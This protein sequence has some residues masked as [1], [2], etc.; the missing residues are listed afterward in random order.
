VSYGFTGIAVALM[1]N[2]NPVGIFLSGILFG[3]LQNG[4]LKMQTL[5]DV[6]SSVVLVVQA[7]IILFIAGRSMFVW[8]QRARAVNAKGPSDP[9][10]PIANAGGESA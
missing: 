9:T 7:L 5:T 2:N 10:K 4:A 6:S 8:R 1:G 3:G